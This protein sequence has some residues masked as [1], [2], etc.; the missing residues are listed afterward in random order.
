MLRKLAAAVVVLGLCLPYACDV[1]PIVGVWDDVPTAMMLGVP[2]IAA[3]VYALQEFLPA[4]AAAIE[5]RGPA[6]LAV[7]RVVYLLLAAAYLVSAVQQSASTEDRL[8]V[9]AAILVT[10]VI[11]VWQRGRGTTAQRVPLH[12][13]AILGL[14][15]VDVLVGVQFDVQLGGWLVTGGWALA[16]LLEMRLLAAMPSRPSG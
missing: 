9:A 14:A 8:S 12:L 6:T 2:L 1:R 13:L 16:L 15:V 4:V 3:F 5:R 11:L 7:L 10:G